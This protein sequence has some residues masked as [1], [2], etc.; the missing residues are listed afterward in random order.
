MT[1]VIDLRSD[2]VSKPTPAM[3]AAMAAAP[4]GDDCYADDPSVNALEAEVAALLGKPAALLLPSGTMANQIAVATHARPGEVLACVAEAHVQVHEDASPARLS[5]VQVEALGDR[6]GFDADTLAARLLEERCGWPRVGLVWM[7]NTLGLAGGL[8]W[9]HEAMRAVFERAQAHRRPVHIDGARLWNAHVASGLPMRTLASV[10]D[11]VSV[12]LSKGL[13]CPVGSVLVGEH[14]FIA[15]A[16]ATRHAFGGALRQAG[17]LAAAGRHALEHHI[18]RLADD[19]RRARALWA[20]L[21]DLPCWT[22]IE[23]QTNIVRF[24]LPAGE[25]A[26]PLCA[27]IRARGVLCH[28]N[29]YAEIRLVVHLGVDDEAVEATVQ[30]VREA[31]LA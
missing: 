14:D 12:C 18:A 25:D 7:E 31:L 4:V 8:V 27:R 30:R 9:P 13:G 6:A 21:K 1:A 24:D 5:G 19:H 3:R 28:P 17:V 23:P 15:R 29:K 20:E 26:E 11:S 10:A 16:R 2:T 22:A